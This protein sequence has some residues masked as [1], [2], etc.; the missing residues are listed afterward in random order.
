MK[1]L[2]LEKVDYDIESKYREE[3]AYLRKER[4][5]QLYKII[6]KKKLAWCQLDEP[7][8]H[9]VLGIERNKRRRMKL[10]MAKLEA[11]ISKEKRRKKIN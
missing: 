3:L 8:I 11:R 10:I 7:Q 4:A 6:K 2:E 1:L 5:E 9:E